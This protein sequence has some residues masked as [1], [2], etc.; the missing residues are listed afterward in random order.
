LHHIESGTVLARSAEAKEIAFTASNKGTQIPPHP[1]TGLD[2][3]ASVI[4]YAGY[5]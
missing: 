4:A 5:A 1:A 2:R 3:Q